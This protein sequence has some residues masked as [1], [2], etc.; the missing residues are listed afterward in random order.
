MLVARCLKGEPDAWET[1]VEIVYKL[2]IKSLSGQGK[3]T[4]QDIEDIVQQMSIALLADD[5]RILR[6]Y[7]PTRARLRTF[8]AGVLSREAS[9]YARQQN[10]KTVL[11]DPL[12]QSGEEDVAEKVAAQVDVEEMLQWAGSPT[13]ILILRLTAW[14]YRAQEIADMLTR[15]QG[16]PITAENVRQRRKR[17]KERLRLR[18]GDKISKFLD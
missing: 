15:S 2:G 6:S 7:D 14:K 9:R 12:L 13:D 3:W 16:R 17:A 5:F 10:R 4:M 11:V 18:F 1:L 8:L